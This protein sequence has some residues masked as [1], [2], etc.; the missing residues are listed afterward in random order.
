MTLLGT[1]LL[2]RQAYD[3]AVTPLQDAVDACTPWRHTDIDL[4]GSG[5]QFNNLAV[6]LLRSNHPD[7]AAEQAKLAIAE[8]PHNPMFVEAL[9]NAFEEA[10]QI[11]QA[12]DI[13]ADVIA[14]DPSQATA[15]N[16]MGVLLAR[17]GKTDA[18]QEQFIAAVRAQ[19]DYGGAWFNL[20]VALGAS[21]GPLTFLQSQ[22]AFAQAARST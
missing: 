21:N 19:P 7:Q 12:I 18:A 15:H 9:A 10:G 8:D 22:G 17:A 14:L 2:K 13:Y 1:S 3:A 20:G 6:A 11:D 5:V 16:N 4:C